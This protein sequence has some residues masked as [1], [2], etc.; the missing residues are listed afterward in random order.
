M[1]V[2]KG[3]ESV[4]QVAGG[5][6]PKYAPVKLSAANTVVVPTADDDEIVGVAQI[7]AASGQEVSVAI[8]GQVIMTAGANGVTLDDLVGLNTADPTKVDTYNAANNDQ[9]IGRAM[10]TAAAGKPAEVL[11]SL[12]SKTA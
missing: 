11:L 1:A 2:Q 9:I 4:S 5:A 10:S 8:A 7:D 12:N 3:V 6:I